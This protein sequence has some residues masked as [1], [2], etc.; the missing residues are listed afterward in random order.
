LARV[1]V[2]IRAALTAETLPIH[3]IWSL[4]GKLLHYAP[5]IPAAKYNINHLIKATS[6]STIRRFPVHITANMKRQLYFWWVMLKTTDGHC[7]IPPPPRNCPPWAITFYTDAAGGSTLSLGQGTGGIGPEFY[8]MVPW[9]RKINAGIRAADG[10][11]LSKK[12][13]ALEL[14]GP[15]ICVAAG[16]DLC[17]SRPVRIWVDNAGSVA[18]WK[19][20]YSSSCALSTTLVNAIGRVAAALGATVYIEKITRRTGDAAILA[21][22]L[23]KGKFDRF[24]HRLP[25]DFILPEAPAWIPPAILAWIADPT[26]DANLGEKILAN[27]REKTTF[28]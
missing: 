15:L 3:E 14:V 7:S 23:S 17:R 20:G 8:F 27:L 24:L 10:R 25:A 28:L 19:K 26:D 18:I 6:L 5:L 16:Y 9:G 1:L 12:L 22:E 21:D 4:V 2:A 13:S 11:Q